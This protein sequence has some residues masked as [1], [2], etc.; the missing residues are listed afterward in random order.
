MSLEDFDADEGVPTDDEPSDNTPDDAV[1]QPYQ[2][3]DPVLDL[4]QARPMIVVD[5]PNQ[6]VDEWS[7][8]NGYDLADN[9]GN[10][11]FDAQPDE[12]VVE[13]VFL[14]NV[15]N[16]PSKTYTFPVSRVVLIDAHHADD[17]RRIGDRVVVDLLESLFGAALDYEHTPTVADVSALVAEAGVGD[18]LQSVASELAKAA[19]IEAADSEADDE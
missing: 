6:T 14:S 18:E 8:S 1:D 13:C 3:G 4:T 10:G 2:K 15:R 11:K 9:Y 17:G 12:A 16:E 19:R 5:A 7:E